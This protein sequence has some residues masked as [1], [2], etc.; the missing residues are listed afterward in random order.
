MLSH[1]TFQKK[2]SNRSQVTLQVG[3]PGSSHSKE[4][5]CST[6]NLGLI[7]GLER[8]PEEGNGYPLQYFCLENPMEMEP[9]KQHSRC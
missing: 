9:G 5:T 2:N 8:S 4:S 1:N 6:G 3:F 7:P